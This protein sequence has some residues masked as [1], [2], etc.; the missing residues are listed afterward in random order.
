MKTIAISTKIGGKRNIAVIVFCIAC[1]LK[2]FYLLPSGS[3]QLGDLFF[4][5]FAGIC[6]VLYSR[7]FVLSNTD[8][9]L[10]LF[11][12]LVFLQNVIHGLFRAPS[13]DTFIGSV[14]VSAYYIYNFL[15]VITFRHVFNNPTA[16][17]SLAK[18]FKLALIFQLVV[19]ATGLGRS[20][21][22]SRY[23]GTFND[24]NQYGFFILT[25]L[26]FVYQIGKLEKD[27]MHI[28]WSL[29]AV[30]LIAPSAST[31][32][33]LGLGGFIL[34]NIICWLYRNLSRSV[35]VSICVIGLVILIVLFVVLFY[36]GINFTVNNA[37]SSIFTRVLS[38]VNK[39]S[40]DF[41]VSFAKDRNMMRVAN[42]P[43]MLIVGSGEGTD[44]AWGVS[45]DERGDIHSDLLSIFF[46]YG[47]ATFS[48]FIIWVALNIKGIDSRYLGIY[49]GLFLES[50]TLVN[51]RQPFF[52][53]LFVLAS[54]SVFKHSNKQTG[55]N[56]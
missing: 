48:L 21:G 24:P 2:Q 49:G 16:L 50:M 43:S 15:I 17:H 4:M 32:M 40:G 30:L 37:N 18:S 7:S 5:L 36:S 10:L 47:I 29:L 42:N 14:L 33:I 22:I 26:F 9:V 54:F 27:K 6:F 19:L 52:W 56:A 44:K 45:F 8:K 25:A 46:S 13:W 53:C 31:G 55:D 12:C 11:V 3:F 41:F 1:F 28:V 51:H 34:V 23:Q 35:F 38:K 39:F 20:Y